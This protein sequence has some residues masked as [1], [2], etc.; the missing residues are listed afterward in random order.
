VSTPNDLLDKVADDLE[1]LEQSLDVHRNPRL[2]TLFVDA[3]AGSNQHVAAA[4]IR[5]SDA[6]ITEGHPAIRRVLAA[7]GFVIEVREGSS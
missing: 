2:R 4:D 7:H 1:G 3:P 5:R 6:I